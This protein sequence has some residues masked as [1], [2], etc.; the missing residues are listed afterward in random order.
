MVCD[1][2]QKPKPDYLSDSSTN[3]VS[4][5]GFRDFLHR[6]LD[7]T[8]THRSRLP[9][10]TTLQLLV[11][12]W[13]SDRTHLR[14]ELERTT[15]FDHLEWL[16]GQKTTPDLAQPLDEVFEFLSIVSRRG[17]WNSQLLQAFAKA[18][19]MTPQRSEIAECRVPGSLRCFRNFVSDILWP[20]GVDRP[21]SGTFGEV[22]KP[23]S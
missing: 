19:K 17:I 8:E 4:S 6:A 14:D 16:I 15:L 2:N 12:F 13:V 7:G 1:A 21:V 23:L 9:T 3:L 11:Y 5:G 22:L 10:S 20:E 18:R